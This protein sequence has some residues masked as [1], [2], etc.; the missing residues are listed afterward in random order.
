MSEP[1]GSR[2]RRIEWDEEELG[3]VA[4][5]AITLLIARPEIGVGEL[6][7]QSQN[8]L[9][10]DRRRPC[11]TGWT[12][13]QRLLEA[14]K[15]KLA[16]MANT[17]R[18]VKLLKGGDDLIAKFAQV[19]A[20]KREFLATANDLIAGTKEEAAA[21][22][23]ELDETKEALA[24]ARKLNAE[25]AAQ[26]AA[27]MERARA[28]EDP[29]PAQVVGKL[30]A[31]AGLWLAEQK[32]EILSDVKAQL[33]HARYLS[34][35]R[36]QAIHGLVAGGRNG[37]PAATPALPADERDGYMPLIVVAGLRREDFQRAQYQVGH[38]QNLRLERLDVSKP[39]HISLGKHDRLVVWANPSSEIPVP[40]VASVLGKSKAAVR[41][42]GTL[43]DLHALIQSEAKA[44]RTGLAPKPARE[45]VPA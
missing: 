42:D 34:E 39:N 1:A 22:Q 35:T 3:R 7:T 26:N 11:V 38:K 24:A 33:D 44:I 40:L 27:L 28:F 23:K 32:R 6:L 12:G 5:A 37:P 29:D 20:E 43:A 21:T 25:L 8:C 17:F 10:E 15:S 36:L 19:D 9:T 14:V 2:R 16:V 18:S 31:M 41:C 13:H 45:E 4:D 30:F